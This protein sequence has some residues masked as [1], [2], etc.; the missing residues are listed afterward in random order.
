ME[1]VGNYF[2]YM[3]ISTKEERNKQ[4][5]N[6]QEQELNRFAKNKNIEYTL[7]FK[8]D[9]SGKNFCERT[10]WNR[11]ESILQ[12]GDTVV[13]KD[14]SRFTREAENGLEKYMKLM[15]QGI[16]LIFIDNPTIS[17]DYIMQLLRV[18]E[19][20]SLIA[21]FSLKNTVQLLLLVE[22][23]RAEQERL[24]IIQRTKDGLAAS[25]KKSG[26]P[27]GK[28]DKLTPELEEEIKHYLSDRSI[29]AASLIKKY[30]I[31]RNTLRKYAKI[32]SEKNL[33]EE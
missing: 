10:E 26:R 17:T 20:Q 25:D 21:K 15:N 33:K 28:L 6:R 2:A 7:V 5:Y 19:A 27:V 9:A 3:R 24:Y 32:V 30:K 29:T 22:L 23:D 13:F 1:R 18:A 14:V 16:Q 31:S 11:L 4:R 8:E 12:S